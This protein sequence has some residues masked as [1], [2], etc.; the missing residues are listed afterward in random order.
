MGQGSGNYCRGGG[1]PL[2]GGLQYS[3]LWVRVLGVEGPGW[4]LPDLEA[5]WEDEAARE[6]VLSTARVLED[7]AAIVGAS[8]HLLGIGWK[9]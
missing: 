1:T 8:A 3:A 9:P 5:R 7:A 2:I 6:V 4:I